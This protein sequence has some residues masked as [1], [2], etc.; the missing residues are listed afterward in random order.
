V[1]L[2]EIDCEV[3]NQFKLRVGYA[4]QLVLQRC[5]TLHK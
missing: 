2:C 4:V 1:D 5:W 3:V